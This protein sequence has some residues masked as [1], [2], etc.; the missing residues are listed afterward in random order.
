MIADLH[1]HSHYSHD[2]LNP[3]RIILKCAK[4]KG[5]DTIAV[6]DH[7]TI[8]GGVEAA[9][10]AK[11]IG[12]DVIIGEEVLTNAGD[13]IGLYLTEDIQSR[14]YNAVIQE[15]HSQGGLVV[16]PH[17]YRGHKIIDEIAPLVD[18][19][20]VWNGRAN[21]IQNMQAYKLAEKF[22][23]KQVIGS[24]AHLIHEVGKVAVRYTSELSIEERIRTQSVS[25]YG[26]YFSQI[27]KKYKIPLISRKL[28]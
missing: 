17:P 12:V 2:S 6:T 20:E 18:F 25:R 11:E 27:M 4:R 14:D 5:L 16:F 8:K 15:I 9:K 24:D 13:I 28:F 1:I 3:P 10:Y 22:H 7:N 23:K 26:V 19:I 21:D